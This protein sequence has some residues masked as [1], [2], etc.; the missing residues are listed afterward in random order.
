M[1]GLTTV[2]GRKAVYRVLFFVTG[3]TKFKVIS[4]TSEDAIALLQRQTRQGSCDTCSLAPAALKVPLS[5]SAFSPGSTFL[6]Q[7]IRP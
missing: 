2:R 3:R 5:F 1:V 6:D 4:V 7:P